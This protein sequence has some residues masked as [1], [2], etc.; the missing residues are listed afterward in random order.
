[1]A[2]EVASG[3]L[4]RPVLK[5]LHHAT[6]KKNLSIAIGLSIVAAV[7]YKFVINDPRKKNYAEFYK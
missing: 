4:A 6:V 5:G 1:M 7:A 2:G 3:G